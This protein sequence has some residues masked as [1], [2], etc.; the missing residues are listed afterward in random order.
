MTNSRMRTRAVALAGVCAALAFGGTAVAG[1]GDPANIK[2]FKAKDAGPG[3]AR[4]SGRIK[5]DNPDC[6][7]HREFFIVHNDVVIV[8]GKTDGKGRFSKKGPRPPRGDKIEIVFPET[9]DCDEES[10]TKTYQD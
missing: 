10:R 7:K 5:S 3:K 8:T 2:S 9:D 6:Y 1:G 4:Y